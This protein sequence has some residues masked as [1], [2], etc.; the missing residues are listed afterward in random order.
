MTTT[1]EAIHLRAQLAGKAKVIELEDAGT[2]WYPCGFASVNIKP[3]RGKFVAFCKQHGIGRPNSYH[4][5]YDISVRDGGAIAD[6]QGGIRP[7]VR[8]SSN[9]ERYQRNRSHND[10]L[11]RHT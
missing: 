4:G 3:A 2:H 5:G 7:R 1:P 9:R 11:R 10:R 6:A 8:P